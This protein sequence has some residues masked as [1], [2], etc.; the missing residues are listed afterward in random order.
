MIL[1]DRINSNDFKQK[2]YRPKIF[3][4]V[5][6]EKI[7]K[8]KRMQEEK[9][10]SE[11]TQTSNIKS[12][13]KFSFNM[14]EI[15]DKNSIATNSN[16]SE[17]KQPKISKIKLPP[18]EQSS[19]TNIEPAPT[20]PVVTHKLEIVEHDENELE[21]LTK[22][23]YF[24]V[25]EIMSE[26][27][28]LDN[29]K[30]HLENE[31]GSFQ[32]TIRSRHLMNNSLFSSDEESD[33]NGDSDNSDQKFIRHNQL[34]PILSQSFTVR[35]KKKHQYLTNSNSLELIN[36]YSSKPN[37]LNTNSLFKQNKLN[38]TFDNE[39]SI[40]T[41]A[42]SSTYLNQ[43]NLTNKSKPYEYNKITNDIYKIFGR[44]KQAIS[45]PQQL[46]NMNKIGKTQS[47]NN[48]SS[49]SIDKILNLKETLSIFSEDLTSAKKMLNYNKN[50][51]AQSEITDISKYLIK[52]Q[53]IIN[54]NSNHFNDIG[55]NKMNNKSKLNNN[56]MKNFA[57]VTSTPT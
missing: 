30:P 34:K 3:D 22:N 50:M 35:K 45:Y 27:M 26:N 17:N 54:N 57:S 11:M 31:F 33:Q 56:N 37:H 7:A 12:S 20:A 14:N 38:H 1:F 18:I 16:I 48:L 6:N 39:G 4:V 51:K 15:L 13:M 43:S 52:K 23:N 9:K 49:N 44:T 24:S 42:F 53:T 40:N 28:Q 29:F 41:F 32:Y 19:T 5:L 36:N 46:S 8:L 2:H 55:Q 21:K 25:D 10:L 47:N